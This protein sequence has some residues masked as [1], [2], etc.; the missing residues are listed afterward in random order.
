MRVFA[1][2]NIWKKLVIILIAITIIAFVTP[3]HVEAGIG[4]S[5]AEPVSSLV[6]T[7]GDGIVW[8]IHQVFY[9][10]G[11]TLIRVSTTSGILGTIL[12]IIGIVV[13]VAVAV[14]ACVFLPGIGE[15]IAA[16]VG[17]SLTTAAASRSCN[18]N[19]YNGCDDWGT[20]S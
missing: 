10:Q 7:I 3:Q 15:A 5:L 4:G 1:N 8:V 14:A 18:N 13:L 2:K 17:A 9:G 20:D 16:S 6:V 19:C 11:Q 12:K